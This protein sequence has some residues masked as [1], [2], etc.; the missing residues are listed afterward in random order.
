MLR[1]DRWKD[2]NGKSMRGISVLRGDGKSVA[3]GAWDGRPDDF[4]ITTHKRYARDPSLVAAIERLT[5]SVYSA[6]DPQTCLRC[7]GR[8]YIAERHVICNGCLGSGERVPQCFR[9]R[10]MLAPSLRGF[11][12]TERTRKCLKK[13]AGSLASSVRFRI[14]ASST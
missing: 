12:K 5:V 10:P 3:M 4:L 7:N 9:F 11:G 8:G 14:P 1:I 2:K 6:E 13:I